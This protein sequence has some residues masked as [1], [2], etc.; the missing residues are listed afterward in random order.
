MAMKEEM[1]SLAE[2]YE[3]VDPPEKQKIFG[4]RWIFRIKMKS[5]DSVDRYRG[6]VIKGYAQKEGIDYNQTFFPVAVRVVLAVIVAENF[7]LSQFDVKPAFLY[8]DINEEVYDICISL[9]IF[10]E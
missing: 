8:G 9:K 5:D 10:N 7:H 1:K 3:L 2:I 6:I 4:N